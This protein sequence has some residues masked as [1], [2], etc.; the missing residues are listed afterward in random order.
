MRTGVVC[1]GG[2]IM[3]GDRDVARLRALQEIVDDTGVICIEM[4]DRVWLGRVADRLVEFSLRVHDLNERL[5][6]ARSEV[7]RLEA[8]VRE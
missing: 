2:G 4:T 8:V 6:E 7:Q 5:L 3:S 1:V